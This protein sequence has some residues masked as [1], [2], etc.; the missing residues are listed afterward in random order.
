MS[1]Q[2][3]QGAA[4][5]RQPQP[6]QPA[7]ARTEQTVNQ[8]PDCGHVRPLTMFRGDRVLRCQDCRLTGG[9]Q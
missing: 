1:S 7:G 3:L 2:Q 5:G 6:V 4:A 8:C 9:G